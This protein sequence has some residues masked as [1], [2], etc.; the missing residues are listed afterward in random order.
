MARRH[1]LRTCQRRR[2]GNRP[3]LHA[4]APLHHCA[5]HKTAHALGRRRCTHRR[6]PASRCWGNRFCLRPLSGWIVEAGRVQRERRSKLAEST[7]ASGARAFSGVFAAHARQLGAERRHVES[8]IVFHLVPSVRR[9]VS[10]S[11]GSLTKPRRILGSEALGDLVLGKRLGR[12]WR[13]LCSRLVRGGRI[14]SS[15]DTQRA[16]VGSGRTPLPRELRIS[17]RSCSIIAP[18]CVEILRGIILS[19]L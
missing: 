17:S 5:L 6:C 12:R 19:R 3:S 4:I 14:S 1:V 9:R 10:A 2:A 16:A 11:V 18:L 15:D 7:L 13:L 8:I